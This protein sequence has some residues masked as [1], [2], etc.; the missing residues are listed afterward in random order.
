M[1][2][3]LQPLMLTFV[4]GRILTTSGM[5]QMGFKTVLLPGIIAMSMVLSG[6]W[7]VAMP[8]AGFP[9]RVPTT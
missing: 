3:L 1:Q 7:A 6:L 2:N 4:F 9:R 5:M 8:R